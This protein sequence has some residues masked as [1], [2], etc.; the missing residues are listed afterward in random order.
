MLDQVLTW[1][2]QE[3][4]DMPYTME[5]FKR[6]VKEQLLKELTPEE[7]LKG[8]PPEERLKDLPS[9]EVLKHLKVE[10]IEAYLDK[11]KRQTEAESSDQT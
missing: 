10:E 2:Q 1:Y 5:D 7:R 6:D 11:L 3:G 4:L 8:L 9:D